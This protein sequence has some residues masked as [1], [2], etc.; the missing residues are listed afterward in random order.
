MFWFL[1]FSLNGIMCESIWSKSG[2]YLHQRH[3]QRK[4]LFPP[5]LLVSLLLAGWWS[6]GSICPPGVNHCL[7]VAWWIMRIFF[8][9][10]SMTQPSATT[11]PV[12]FFRDVISTP[13]ELSCSRSNWKS[14]FWIK[15]T[16]GIKEISLIRENILLAC[17]PAISRYKSRKSGKIGTENITG[18]F[19]RILAWMILDVVRRVL[20]TGC[21][22]LAYLGDHR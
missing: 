18:L 19:L 5:K 9:F 11:W 17:T 3:K 22:R 8:F 21:S 2:F 1:F 10:G 20:N 4:H 7:W 6:V 12:K 13:S 14:F 15:R 16:V